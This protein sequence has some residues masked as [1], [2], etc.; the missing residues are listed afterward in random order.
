MSEQ[1][2][3]IGHYGRADVLSRVVAAAR[4]TA[5]D[6]DRLTASDFRSQDQ[7]HAGGF[8]A[9]ER[10]AAAA[11]FVAG[12]GLLDAGSGLGGSARYLVERYGVTVDA[13]DLTPDFVAAARE[14]DRL[15]G[16]DRLITQHLGSVLALPFNPGL[17]DVV[18]CQYVAMNVDDKPKMFAEFFRVLKPGGR[19]VLALAAAGPAGPPVY[20]MPWARSADY[21]FLVT[22]QAIT[23]GLT[24]AGFRLRTVDLPPPAARPDGPVK[25]AAMGDQ[26]AAVQAAFVEAMAAGQVQ[27]MS[28]IAD[29]PA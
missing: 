28:V 26:M 17:F 6:P 8:A 19:L 4:A 16:L 22:P 3:V 1:G 11:G 29:R 7:L 5:A 21:S 13:V 18:W 15:C 2:Q 27:P 14:I 25:A 23:Q 12:E 24:S 10:L 9:T 20:P